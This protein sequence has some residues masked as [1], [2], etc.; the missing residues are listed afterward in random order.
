MLNDLLEVTKLV[1]LSWDSN[2]STTVQS[3]LNLNSMH[4]LLFLLFTCSAMS[5]SLWSHGHN[6]SGSSVRGIF[7][8]RILQWAAISFSRV[9]GSQGWKTKNQSHGCSSEKNLTHFKCKAQFYIHRQYR[10]RHTDICGGAVRKI[11]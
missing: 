9:H 5:N 2:S 4:F 6:L 1:W 11:G 10:N 8:A 7:Q 3:A